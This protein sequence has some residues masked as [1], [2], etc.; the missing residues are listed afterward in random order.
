LARLRLSLRSRH[1]SPRTEQAYLAWIR[2]FVAFHGRKHPRELGAPDIEAFLDHLAANRQVSA[3]T[4]NQALSA[5]L[6]LY[7]V[8]ERDLGEFRGVVR[9]KRPE[10]LPVVLTPSE[11]SLLLAQMTGVTSLM[12]RLMYGAGLRLAECT[13]LR[14][15]DL[16]LERREIRI[17]DGKGRKDRVAPLPRILIDPIARHLD[18]VRDQHRADLQLGA[19]FVELPDGLARKYPNAPREWPWQWLFP[20]TRGYIHP[21]TGQRRRHH[22]HDTVVQRAV[23]RA[24]LAAGLSKPVSPHTLRHCFATHLLEAGYDIRTIQ[25]LLGHRDVATTMIYTHVLNRGAL[26]VESPLDRLAAP[27][28][29]SRPR[30]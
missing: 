26:G 6:F 22:L 27:H 1:Y 12:S 29:H 17:R 2:R 15:K 21:A 18:A 20:A 3:S 13:S 23:R 4:Q 11:V 16:A 14:I 10:R 24:A 19:G 30:F 9:A 8:L 5:L 7:Q 25:E 28:P